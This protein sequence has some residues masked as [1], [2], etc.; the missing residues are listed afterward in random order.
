MAVSNLFA[1]WLSI[2]REAHEIVKGFWRWL[3]AERCNSCPIPVFRVN[4]ILKSQG[5]FNLNADW[6]GA[7]AVGYTDGFAVREN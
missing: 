7:R 5:F 6:Q 4:D 1:R 2:E 3:V